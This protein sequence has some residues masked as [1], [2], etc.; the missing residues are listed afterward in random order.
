MS[1]DRGKL[2]VVSGPSAAG[3]GTVIGEFFKKYKDDSIFLSI[4]AT[5]RKPR[6]GEVEGV[7]YYYKTPEEFERMKRND[8]LLEWA[9]FCGN[10]YGTPKSAVEKMLDEGKDVILEIEVQGAAKVKALAPDGIFVFVFPPSFEE[11]EKRLIDRKTESMEVIRERLATAR[12]EVKQIDK[13]KYILLNDTIE[14]AVDRLNAI[15]C[16]ER[17][18]VERNTKL[19]GEML[20]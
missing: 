17:C 19:I 7:N 20:K 4:S 14:N 9:E 1:K 16:A 3:K 12:E 2:F 6:Q 10:N 11:L 15:I 18:L 8:E 13:Y 5:T